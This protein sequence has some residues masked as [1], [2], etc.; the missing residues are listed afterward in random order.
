MDIVAYALVSFAVG[1][2]A[3]FQGIYERFRSDSLKAGGTLY[4]LAFLSS[5]G[6]IAALAFE[7]LPSPSFLIG[8]PLW[9]ALI[10]GASVEVI[11]RSKFYLK[12]I[13]AGGGKFDDLVRGPFDL[14][15]VYQD[16]FLT[17]IENNFVSE[18]ISRAAAASARYQEFP[19][20][21]LAFE[22]NIGAFRQDRQD[23]VGAK[24]AATSLMAK[25][26]EDLEESESAIDPSSDKKYRYQLCYI[27][28]SF[29]G[30]DAI[31]TIF[32]DGSSS[33]QQH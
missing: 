10:Y 33:P 12:R 14:L 32:H 16:F 27:V 13:S 31:E 19:K 21:W 1:F 7:T 6:A 30:K 2:L 18:T 15:R 5:R 28:D 11:L 17:S 24:K 25:Y 22:Q 4:G 9:R 20:M 29:L 3:G 23:V 26:R 8:H